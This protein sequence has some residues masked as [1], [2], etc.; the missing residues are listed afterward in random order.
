MTSY[1]RGPELELLTQTTHQRLLQIAGRFGDRDALVVR[2]QNI[3]LSWRMLAGEIER[4]ARGLIGLGLEPGDRVGVWAT[5]CAEW[6]YLQLGCARAGLVQVNVNPAYRV[7]ELRYVLKKSGMKA[8]VLRGEDWRSNYR[9]ILDGAR[10][11]EEL[12]LRHVVYLGED[13]WMKMINGGLDAGPGPRDCHD[14]VNIQYTSGTTGSPKGVLLTHHNLVNNGRIIADSLRISEADRICVP[15]P[16]YHCFGCVGG[17]MV[18][19][20]TGAAI[21]LPAP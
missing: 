1:A 14:V 2:H 17:T 5:N 21:I 7:H 12:A 20:N 15:V 10:N 4:T 8:L 18:A 16:M 3:R 13:S 6:I 11:G 9:A 19:I